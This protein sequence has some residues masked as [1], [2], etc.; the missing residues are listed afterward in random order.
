MRLTED[1]ERKAKYRARVKDVI[2][3]AEDIKQSTSTAALASAASSSSA[4]VTPLT[5]SASPARPA[6]TSFAAADHSRK[7]SATASP[8][9]V[10]GEMDLSAL[11]A[12]LPDAPAVP[13]D[14]AGEVAAAA[15]A[16]AA[17][18]GGDAHVRS[19]SA[20]SARGGAAAADGKSGV[21]RKPSGTN[22]TKSE[23]EVLRRS[24]VING[25]LYM[26][27][28][29]IDTAE[30]FVYPSPFEDPDGLLPLDRKQVRRHCGQRP[31]C[32]GGLTLTR[33]G[34]ASGWVAGCGPVSLCA[35]SRA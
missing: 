22:M 34:S 18:G 27:W 24:S 12:V 21:Q 32:A 2:A 17:G 11:Q 14:G 16:G 28:L 23:L 9:G 25:K 30:R 35:G 29:D 26:P 20:G 1:A 4:P 15:A 19:R 31:H 13:T 7:G 3:R 6:S 10:A 5:H 8:V 33:A